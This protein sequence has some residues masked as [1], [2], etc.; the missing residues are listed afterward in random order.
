MTMYIAGMGASWKLIAG[1][2]LASG[3]ASLS[4]CQDLGL[5][6]RLGAIFWFMIAIAFGLSAL[7]TAMRSNI[8]YASAICL[9]VLCSQT[10]SILYW[11]LKRKPQ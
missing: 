6:V 2:L 3:V 7:S 5:R 10:L 11:A 4:A 8:R 9:L 1:Q